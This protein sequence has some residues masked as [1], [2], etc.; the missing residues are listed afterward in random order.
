MPKFLVR[1]DVGCGRWVG[2][3]VG[4]KKGTVGGIGA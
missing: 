3:T 2:K 4:K 1:S